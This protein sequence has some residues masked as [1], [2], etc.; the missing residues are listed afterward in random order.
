VGSDLGLYKQQPKLARV[1]PIN[2]F[3][4]VL[5]PAHCGHILFGFFPFIITS[6]R[7]LFRNP[8]WQNQ[9]SLLDDNGD[10]LSAQPRAT[11]AKQT[12]PVVRLTPENFR[13]VK[14]H[15]AKVRGLVHNKEK[16][17]AFLDFNLRLLSQGVRPKWMA[18][19]PNPPLLPGYIPF[20]GEFHDTWK[21]VTAKYERKLHKYVTRHLPTV[22]DAMGDQISVE[23]EASLQ[24]LKAAIEDS[25][26]RKRAEN[27]F[28]RFVNKQDDFSP[29]PLKTMHGGTP[30]RRELY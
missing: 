5:A 16:T 22:I 7:F 18:P 8:R 21:T 1:T 3:H 25:T 23:R 9:L 2:K 12:S 19:T 14:Q 4:F 20:P 28:R 24:R 11:V 10:L 26:Q 27:L 30:D 17:Q 6:Y 13:L 29:R 15:S